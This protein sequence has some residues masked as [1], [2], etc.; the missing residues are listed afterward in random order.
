MNNLENPE[1]NNSHNPLITELATLEKEK[2]DKKG[3]DIELIQKEIDSI[4]QEIKQNGDIAEKETRGDDTQ[5]FSREEVENYQKVVAEME[6]AEGQAE[7]KKEFEALPPEEQKKVALGLQNVGYYIEENK[8]KFFSNTFE[9]IRGGAVAKGWIKENGALDRFFGVLS[10]NAKN[11]AEENKKKFDEAQKTIRGEVSNVGSVVG[12]IT[13]Y[14]RTVLDAVGVTAGAPLR[15]VMMGSMLFGTGADA[16][17]EAR[18]KNEEVLEKTH[19]KDIDAAAGEA[20]K[21]YN[22]AKN[23]DGV[24]SKKDLDVAYKAGIPAD[25]LARLQKEPEPGVASGILQRIIKWD[26]EDSVKR[27][28]GKLE[29]IENDKG[30]SEE[31]KKARQQKIL[32]KYSKHLHDLDRAVGQVG[33]VDALALGAKYAETTARAAVT[34][35]TIESLAMTAYKLWENMPKILHTARD[36]WDGRAGLEVA[37]AVA[38]N[39]SMEHGKIVISEAAII[40]KGEGIEH[41]F[42][43]QLSDEPEKFGYTGD[44]ED[45]NAIK[46]WAGSQAHRLA[47]SEGYAEMDGNREIRIGGNGENVAIQI[48]KDPSGHI[49]VNEYL[50]NDDGTF[51]EGSDTY[52]Y[53]RPVNVETPA[54]GTIPAKGN[55]DANQLVKET[56]AAVSA[57]EILHKTGNTEINP[58]DTYSFKH[59]IDPNQLSQETSVAAST[60]EILDKMGNTEINPG[61]THEFSTDVTNTEHSASTSGRHY[62]STLEATTSSA[63]LRGVTGKEFLTKDFASKIKV[64]PIWGDIERKAAMN[65]SRNISVRMNMYE[66]LMRSGKTTEATKHLAKLYEYINF[67]EKFIGEGIID[68][69]KIPKITK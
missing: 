18:F 41:A 51:S 37:P 36:Y 3:A 24:A 61:N 30:L 13:K 17:K 16:A 25:L 31:E 2:L 5:I 68:K 48:E 12:N 21:I 22:K 58:G 47:I 63:I 46:Q 45:E 34:A 64:D 69:T 57:D 56:S 39:P 44:M 67:H 9:N 19:V 59:V 4:E 27:I 6:S 26:V 10:Q 53:E 60:N 42:I 8:S 43:R 54:E 20:W 29:K 11:D 55:L 7:I 33:T 40:H 15:Y 32:D 49:V 35:M 38:I 65:I 62:Q 28:N 50:Q 14:S 52:E 23:E 66:K 1:F